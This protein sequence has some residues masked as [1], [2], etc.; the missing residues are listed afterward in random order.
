MT[1]KGQKSSSTQV[2][3][4][5]ND[6]DY[7]QI[8]EICRPF[9]FPIDDSSVTMSLS[10]RLDDILVVRVV[11]PPPQ[12]VSSYLDL[13]ILPLEYLWLLYFLKA[14]TQ[15]KFDIFAVQNTSETNV[16]ESETNNRWR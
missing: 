2:S 10:P 14:S 3:T 6:K 12:E 4:M 16:L 1:L 9:Y 7:M 13:T 11:T 15:I 8:L 5:P